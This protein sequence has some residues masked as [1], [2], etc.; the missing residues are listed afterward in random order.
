MKMVLRKSSLD[1]HIGFRVSQADFSQIQTRADRA[2]KP[3][4]AWCRERVI[5]AA[6]RPIIS[7]GEFATLSEICAVEEIMIE[8]LYAIVTEVEPSKERFRQITSRAHAAK[9]N[10][11]WKLLDRVRP[12]PEHSHSM[13]PARAI[14]P[15]ANA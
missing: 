13:L 10:E 15:V 4:N 12:R 1:Y 7:V 14:E 2:G 9:N 11:A 8:L 6:Q 3:A 5:E